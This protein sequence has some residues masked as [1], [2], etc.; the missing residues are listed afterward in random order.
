VKTLRRL[1]RNGHSTH[2]AIESRLLEFLRWRAGDYVVVE[3]TERGTLEIRHAVG[4][5]LRAVAP[6]RVQDGLPLEATR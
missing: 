3:L 1:T 4:T 2:V 6:A 5:D